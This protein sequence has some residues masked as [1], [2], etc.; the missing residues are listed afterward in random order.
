MSDSVFYSLCN[1][2]VRKSGRQRGYKFAEFCTSIGYNCLQVIA[3]Y[4][5]INVAFN[6]NLDRWIQW[7]KPAG[8]RTKCCSILC[9]STPFSDGG[10]WDRWNACQCPPH[11]LS[12]QTCACT[13]TIC[14]QT[15][16]W[17][18]SWLLSLGQ[19]MWHNWSWLLDTNWP[20]CMCVC[21]Q[22]N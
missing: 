19:Q 8:E 13:H 20:F 10:Q 9:H 11:S 3:V 17:A 18:F 1:G 21:L 6:R 12:K 22:C 15:K 4:E 16:T 14:S 5:T 2:E 7:Q